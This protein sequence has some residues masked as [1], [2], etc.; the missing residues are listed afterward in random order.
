MQFV[1]SEMP[2]L[3]SSVVLEIPVDVNVQA[4]TAYSGEKLHVEKR[5]LLIALETFKSY[6][7]TL[8]ITH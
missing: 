7:V 6:I 1:T 5:A 8:S 4:V 3:W 2:V